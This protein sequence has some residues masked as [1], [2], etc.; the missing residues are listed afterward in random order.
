MNDRTYA[1]VDTVSFTQALTSGEIDQSL[2]FSLIIETS[3]NTLRYSIDHSQFLIKSDV[4][5][6]ILYLEA[7][8]SELGIGYTVYNYQTVFNVLSTTAWTTSGV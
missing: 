7:R 8:A 3:S 6:N 2:F 5:E 4:P 1:I